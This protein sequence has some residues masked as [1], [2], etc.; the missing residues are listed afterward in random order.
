MTRYLI[1]ACALLAAQDSPTNNALV[2]RVEIPAGVWRQESAGFVCAWRREFVPGRDML[3]GNIYAD[4][5]V[6]LVRDCR[7][8]CRYDDMRP[9]V[10]VPV[11]LWVGGKK[12][13]VRGWL[14]LPR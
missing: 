13:D 8:N 14:H 11:A 12:T 1:L 9:G 6:R 10:D 5:T 7:G 3:G 4:N 2:E